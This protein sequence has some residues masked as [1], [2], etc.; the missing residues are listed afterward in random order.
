M[1]G[2]YFFSQD[3]CYQLMYCF[4]MSP[5]AVLGG[6]GYRLKMSM[7]VHLKAQF[8]GNQCTPNFK[9]RIFGAE[10]MTAHRFSIWSKHIQNTTSVIRLHKKNARQ[11]YP[12]LKIKFWAIISSSQQTHFRRGVVALIRIGSCNKHTTDWYPRYF[13]LNS[14]LVMPEYGFISMPTLVKSK[15]AR[16]TKPL[17]LTGF[18][19]EIPAWMRKNYTESVSKLI[20]GLTK[21]WRVISSIIMCGMK[22]LIHS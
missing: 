2:K 13:L 7:C 11:V 6:F 1:T 21:T 17:L 16:Y 22:L 10:S 9:V 18:N 15:A 20:L 14:S 3:L 12:N 5:W 19:F 4:D 8:T